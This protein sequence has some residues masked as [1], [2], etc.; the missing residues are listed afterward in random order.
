M[1]AQD[2]R[3]HS[4]STLCE[5]MIALF[6][7]IAIN[8]LVGSSRAGEPG[9]ADAADASP[10]TETS[11]LA[12][13]AD[14]QRRVMAIPEDDRVALKDIATIASDGEHVGENPSR[15]EDKILSRIKNRMLKANGRSIVKSRQEFDQLYEE[16][17]LK[18]CRAVQSIYD[19]YKQACDSDDTLV[20]FKIVARLCMEKL[21]DPSRRRE[22]C[23]RVQYKCLLSA[24]AGTILTTGLLRP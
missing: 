13:L 9:P 16:H 2:V 4:V 6:L 17:I 21:T 10:A 18:P 20:L 23:R 11:P 15:T 22:F 1:L 14:V 8:C 24:Y 19:D 5:N 3:C 7:L 12:L